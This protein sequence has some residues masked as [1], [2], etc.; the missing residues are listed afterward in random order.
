M[1]LPA[2]TDTIVLLDDATRPEAPVLENLSESEMR[3]GRHL[4]MIHDHQRQNMAV[5]RNLIDRARSGALTAADLDGAL[6]G[7]SLLDNYRRFGNLCGQHCQIVHTHHSIEDS[8]VFPELS[9]KAEAFRRVVD[10]LIEEHGVIHALLTRLLDELSLLVETP[11]ASAFEAAAATYNRLETLL[12][13]H[14]NYE[15]RSIGPAL[16]RFRIGV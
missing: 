15:E 10:R 11:D 3:P 6:D 14:F 5:L 8:Y 1:E 13:S 12:L 4:A 16:G 7:L 9:A 2:M